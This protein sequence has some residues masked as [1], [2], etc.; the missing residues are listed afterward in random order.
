MICRGN[1]T[2]VSPGKNEGILEAANLI[3][4]GNRMLEEPFTVI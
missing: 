3:L 4:I 1:L 2:D